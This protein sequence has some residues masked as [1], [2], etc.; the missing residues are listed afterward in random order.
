[1]SDVLNFDKDCVFCKIIKG[2][3]PSSKVYEDNFCF[4]FRDIN[5][6]APVHI[7]VI[8]K[9]HIE[10]CADITEGNAALVGHIF[11]AIAKIAKQEKLDGGFR[12]I[13]NSGDDAGQ[14]VHH[15]HFHILAGTKMGEGL[16]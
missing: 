15:L 14:T 2:D 5:P 13:S 7:L 1:M 8:P 10:S 12:V 16:I 9:A 6:Q 11:K 3:I 4:A